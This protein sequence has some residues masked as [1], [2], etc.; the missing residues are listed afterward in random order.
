MIS[1][2]QVKAE[3]MV[4]AVGLDT[5]ELAEDRGFLVGVHCLQAVK[6]TLANLR[7]KEIY[8]KW[9]RVGECLGLQKD[10]K[11]G[12]LKGSKWRGSFQGQPWTE[13]A[14]P[15]S[16]CALLLT[17][18]IGLPSLLGS[19]RVQRRVKRIEGCSQRVP[20]GNWVMV[21]K[22]KEICVDKNNRYLVWMIM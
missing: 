6:P 10:F 17:E 3:N 12:Q 15:W 14:L 2:I 7:K 13:S 11:Q 22:G 5:N 18:R 1:T 20:K 4:Y 21:T 8:L 19:T 16:L 9:Y